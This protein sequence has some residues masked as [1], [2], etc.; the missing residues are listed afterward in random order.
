MGAA[1]RRPALVV[2]VVGVLALAGVAGALTLSTSAGTDTLV[3]RDTA[4]WRATQDHRARFGDDPVYVLVRGPLARTIL[5]SDLSR[6]IGLEGCL[7]GAAPP[8]AAQPGG[9]AG[10]CARL[11]RSGAVRY[12]LGPGTFINES[13][14][15]IAG[16]FEQ[17]RRASVAKA[18]RAARAARRLALSRGVDPRR[19]A[20]YASAA[21]RLVEAQFAQQVISLGLA[22]GLRSVPRINDPAFVS[23]LVFTDT[24]PVGTPKPRFSYLFPSGDSALVQVRLRSGLSDAERARAIGIVRDAVRMPQWRLQNGGRYVVTGAPVLVADLTDAI[25]SALRIL[26]L[27]ALVVMALTLGVVFRA[28]MRLLP[29]LVAL[30]ATAMTFGLLALVGQSLTMASVGVLPILVGLGVDYGI[31]LQ[32]RVMEE[33]VRTRSHRQAAAAAARAGVPTIAIAACATAAGFLVVALSPVPMV[34][35]F[36]LVLVAGILIALLCAL[37]LGTAVLVFVGDG[38]H[39]APAWLRRPSDAFGAAWRGAGEL[40]TTS[41]VAVRAAAAGRRLRNGSLRLVTMHPGRA[42]AVALVLAGLGWGLE[43]RTGVESNIERLVPADLPGLQGL[44]ALQAGTGVAGE[45]DVLVQGRRLTDPKVITWMADYQRRVLRRYGYSAARGCGKAELCPSFSLS[46]LAAAGGAKTSGQVDALLSAVPAYFSQGVL[47]RDRRS[48]SLAFG[49]KLDGL[50]RQLEVMRGMEAE[51]NPPPGVRARLAGLTVLVAQ[52]NDRIASVG[53]RFLALAL[54]L[55]A[56][57]LVLLAALRSVS[58]A[59]LP[60]VPI[61]LAAGWSALVLA[62]VR[63]PLNPMS[64]ALGTLVI[65]IATEFSVLLSERYRRERLGGH[66][67]GRALARTYRTTGAAV[68]A[69]GL[70]AIAGFAVLILSD[71]RMLRDFGAVTVIDLAVALLGVLLILPAVLTLAERRRERRA[72]RAEGAGSAPEPAAPEPAPVA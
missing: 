16:Q 4:A 34:R 11:A 9:P 66:P 26:L 72:G 15:Q 30:C 17:R 71:I 42:L 64:V 57:A 31:Q 3:G 41:R 47:T 12:V 8:K 10:P 22:Y 1:A 70:T 62:I 56:V 51:L 40:I 68:V 25:T 24:G 36:G 55:L 14:R 45:V 52:A 39:T 50:D 6:L 58:R 29:L 43:A 23:Q 37:A 38:D 27:G 48:A 46:D 7:A 61:A 59:L 32:S 19:A 2:V 18:E 44:K 20:Q 35:Q 63:V 67:H 33:R 53:R 54:G 65:A 21:R 60:L 13:V 49:I 69:S 28:R 5:T